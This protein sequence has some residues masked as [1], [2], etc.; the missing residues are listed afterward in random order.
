MNNPRNRVVEGAGLLSDNTTDLLFADQKKKEVFG[1]QEHV[2][3]K[4]GD[5]NFSMLIGNSLPFNATRDYNNMLPPTKQP[6]FK[7]YDSLDVGIASFRA[8]RDLDRVLV[9]SM[10]FEDG[11]GLKANSTRRDFS[12]KQDKIVSWKTLPDEANRNGTNKG[13]TEGTVSKNSS[14][15][16][17]NARNI[18]QLVDKE[19]AKLIAEQ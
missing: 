19:Y 3:K 7:V 9:K 5:S 17:E 13:K 18:L 14:I 6:N 2:K 4:L 8:Q 1:M 10:N 12:L 15:L 16:R 11:K